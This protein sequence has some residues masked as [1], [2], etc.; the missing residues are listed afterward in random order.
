MTADTT[1]VRAEEILDVA[2][3]SDY[4]DREGFRVADDDPLP[5]EKG[6][7]RARFRIRTTSAFGD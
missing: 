3:L 1:T 2:R 4:L 6:T 7:Y 5:S